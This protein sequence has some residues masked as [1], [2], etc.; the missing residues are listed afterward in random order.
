MAST[1]HDRA[2]ALREQGLDAHQ[3]AERVGR[4]RRTVQELFR[5]GAGKARP[6][7]EIIPQVLENILKAMRKN[8]RKSKKQEPRQPWQ[9]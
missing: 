6:I 3:I 2:M 8:A 9:E 5:T 4:D 7:G 1:W